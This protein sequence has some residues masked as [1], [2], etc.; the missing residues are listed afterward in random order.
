M[1]SLSEILD[2]TLTKVAAHQILMFDE[3]ATEK[4][5]R[6]GDKTNHFLGAWTKVK[7]IL[8]AGEAAKRQYE[9][10]FLKIQI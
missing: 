7:Y 6:W 5:L 9:S 2:S 10:I 1:D 8:L 4:R 3:I